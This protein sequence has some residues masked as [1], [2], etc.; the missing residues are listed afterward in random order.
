M[1]IG[2]SV[3]KPTPPELTLPLQIA[4][5]PFTNLDSDSSNLGLILQ[6]DIIK[7]LKCM[8]EV[9]TLAVSSVNQSL[10]GGFR[11]ED[12][13]TEYDV[14][15][16]FEGSHRTHL[17]G[18]EL[19]IRIINTR[20]GYTLWHISLVIERLNPEQEVG[21]IQEKVVPIVEHKIGA[22]R[23]HIKQPERKG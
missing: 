8:S 7:A 5:L 11:P 16:L 23:D 9:K 15:I 6:E 20:T 22:L 13:A 12:Y 3:S 19:N 4:V 10:K 2:W 17:E 18:H 1:F 21:P 14:D